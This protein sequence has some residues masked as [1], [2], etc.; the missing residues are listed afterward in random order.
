MSKKFNLDQDDFMPSNLT[1][2]AAPAEQTTDGKMIGRRF[3]KNVAKIELDRI[4]IRDQVRKTYNQAG[5]EEMA[6]SLT[7]LGQQQPIVVRWDET[8]E[9]N[10]RYVVLMGHRRFL[11]SKAAGFETVD[12]VIFERDLNDAEIV[13]LQ[14]I[15][16]VVREDL[17]PIEEAIAF[18]QLIDNRKASGQPSKVEDVAAFIGVSATKVFRAIRLLNLPEDVQEDVAQGTIP[19]SVIREV[20]K[21][22]TEDEQRQM[23]ERYKAGESYGEIAKSVKAKKSGKGTSAG[24]K[25][26]KAFT[27]GPIK[28]QATAK[29]RVTQAEIAEALEAW[30]EELRG[31]GRS[32]NRAA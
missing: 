28:L 12:A 7:A 9:D 2:T 24:P 15:E 29:K 21:L 26:K 4:I 32:Q 1:L 19:T 3:M 17:N 14:L 13:E 8:A 11:G 23:I 10:G 20:L 27:A 6:D 16:N 25:T 18:R 22:K 30:I 31:D 5:I